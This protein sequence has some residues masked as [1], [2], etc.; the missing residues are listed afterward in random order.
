MRDITKMPI[1]GTL[2]TKEVEYTVTSHLK[3]SNNVSKHTLPK[4]T[5]S[6]VEIQE[7]NGH[8]YYITNLWYK[9]YKG[10]PQIIVDELVEEYT[11]ANGMYNNGGSILLAPNRK[12]SKLTPEQYKLVRTDEFISW[13]GDWENSP[14]TA[15][16]VVDENGEPLVLWHYARRLQYKLDKFFVFRTAEQLGSH[17][18]SLSQVSNLSPDAEYKIDKNELDFRFYEVFLNIRNPIRMLDT[19]YWENQDL[20]DALSEKYN[21]YEN[22]EWQDGERYAKHYA[23]KYSIDGIIY[24]NRYETK[25]DLTDS[26]KKLTDKEFRKLVTSAEDSWIAFNPTQIKLADGTNTTFDSNNPDI[27]YKAGGEIQEHKETYKKWKSLVNMSKTELEKFYN[28]QE[29]KD[30]GLSS[31]EASSQGISSGRESA[32]WI[33]RM[34]DTPVSEWTPSMWRWANKQIS[35]ISRMS[36]NKGPLYD[37]K[38]RKTRKH[39]SLLIWGHNPKKYE[40]GGLFHGSSND[41]CDTGFDIKTV[42]DSFKKEALGWGIYFTSERD[43]AMSYAELPSEKYAISY[44]AALKILSENKKVIGKKFLEPV[45]IELSFPKNII[46]LERENKKDFKWYRSVDFPKIYRVILHKGKLPSQYDYAENIVTEKQL[47]KIYSQAKRESVDLS[48]LNNYFINFLKQEIEKLKV[49]LV[50]KKATMIQNYNFEKSVN[51]EIS[52]IEADIND[53]KL[54]KKKINLLF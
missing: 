31:S 14:E 53:V 13:F 35:F 18:G 12:S 26:Q 30:A 33:M 7:H 52:I 38:G 48:K 37:E 41:F 39:T 8:T 43:I 1:I 50:E 27:R 3:D 11:P 29:G 9:E 15:S 51:D 10:E 21:I 47:L 17:F 49:F 4:E 44:E 22:K 2:T 36:G 16:K 28:S 45:G 5:Y 54:G 6:I 46:E 24:L 34:K 32:R 20:L 42:G 19:P 40:L 23:E 25:N